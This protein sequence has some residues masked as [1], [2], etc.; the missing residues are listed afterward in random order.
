MYTNRSPNEFCDDSYKEC[1]F[2]FEVQT[3]HLY[4]VDLDRKFLRIL[5]FQP[6][7]IS[8]YRGRGKS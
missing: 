5:E 7:Q 3:F 2:P 8:V 4:D 1:P 6:I